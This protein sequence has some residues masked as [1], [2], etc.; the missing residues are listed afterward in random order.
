MSKAATRYLQTSKAKEKEATA[1]IEMK[2]TQSTEADSLGQ[3]QLAP[4]ID[5]LTSWIHVASK[6]KVL[7]VSTKTQHQ[8]KAKTSN[9]MKTLQ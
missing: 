4:N 2:V 6:R 1:P 7:G 5:K 3:T 9:K 8:S